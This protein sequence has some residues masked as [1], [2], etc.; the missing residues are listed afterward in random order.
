MS[1]RFAFKTGYESDEV[2]LGFAL[3]VALHALP[4]LLVVLKAMYP[5]AA[6]EEEPLVG[7][8]MVAASLLK[9]GKP[10]D[11]KKLPDRIVPQA[12]TA[13][14][15]E[16]VASREEKLKDTPDAGAP[17][18]RTED[19]DLTNLVAKTDPFAE[20]S[21][22]THPEEGHE[23]GVAEGTETDPSK[24]RAGD[25]YAAQLN[26]F[27]R[28]HWSFPSVISQGQA[29]RLCV[30]VQFTLDRRM[31]IWHVRSSPVK[32]SGN[33]LFDD[34][35]MTMLQKLMDDKTPLPEPPP[36]VEQQFRGRAIPIGLTGGNGDACK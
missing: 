18:P 15:K 33:E 5:S 36:E 16:L 14:K 19:S 4:V 17:P 8:P 1:S 9:L 21:A 26:K 20:N 23:L 34:S 11:P 7:R 35:A 32:S 22:K 2:A 24:V 13:P 25:M 31:V 6:E 27:F 10:L 29:S 3:A 28:D 30:Y 12:R